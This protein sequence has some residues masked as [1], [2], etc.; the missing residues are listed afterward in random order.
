MK[1]RADFSLW[2]RNAPSAQRVKP[3]LANTAGRLSGVSFNNSGGHD[4]Q[5][6]SF[7][8]VHNRPRRARRVRLDR[9][10]EQLRAADPGQGVSVTTV[11]AGWGFASP[12][13]F[14]AHYRAVYGELPSH[15]LRGKV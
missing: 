12:S 10:R 11:A 9:A 2:S 8:G 5:D 4:A 1:A 13:R 14:T 6:L 15:T 7:G 3:Y